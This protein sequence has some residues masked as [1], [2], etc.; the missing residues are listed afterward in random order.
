MGF[1]DDM[2]G[3]REK[4]PTMTGTQK[5]LVNRISLNLKRYL[6]T[7]PRDFSFEPYEGQ[8]VPDV[9]ANTQAAI[10][11]AGGLLQQD[12][13]MQSAVADLLSGAGDPESVRQ[14]YEQ[15]VVAPA[16]QEFED[17]LRLVDDRYGDTWGP[18]G[19]HQRMVADATSRFGTGIGSVLG[20]LVYR[21]RNAARDRQY[22]GVQAGIGANTDYMNRL[23]A[24]LGI[25]DYQRGLQ[26]EELAGDLAKWQQS[27]PYNNPWL[28]FLGP[29]LG[30]QTFAYGEKPG[31]LEQAVAGRQAFEGLFDQSIL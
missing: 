6:D 28:G 1:L 30:S 4:V 29:A 7:A 14:F 15:S 23:G 19:A 18:T 10:D 27:Q 8:I 16:E 20:E 31:L 17:A 3:G 21:D 22:Q 12:P 24:T 25:G 13:A 5:D 2:F 26:G 9:N 11:Q